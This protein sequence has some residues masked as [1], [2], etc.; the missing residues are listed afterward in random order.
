M[1]PLQEHQTCLSVSVVSVL[2][3]SDF[4]P[5]MSPLDPSKW[6]LC[7]GYVREAYSTVMEAKTLE[8]LSLNSVVF[9]E[10]ECKSCKGCGISDAKPCKW[11]SQ[12][13]TNTQRSEHTQY[14]LNETTHANDSHSTHACV[15]H[16]LQTHRPEHG[17][18]FQPSVTLTV[19]LCLAT[20]AVEMSNCVYNV[21]LTLYTNYQYKVALMLS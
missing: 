20:A 10:W 11:A 13:R 17:Q 7:V 9:S 5:W 8:M 2:C 21:L 19:R 3:S 6:L 1:Y 15:P 4:Q 12:S 18:I 16:T 14:C